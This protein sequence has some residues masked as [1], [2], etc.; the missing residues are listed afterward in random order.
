MPKN[1]Y[2]SKKPFVADLTLCDFSSLDWDGEG[3]LKI[4]QDRGR[5]TA[6]LHFKPGEAIR[7]TMNGRNVRMARITVP[8]T[9]N[10]TVLWVCCAEK[11]ARVRNEEEF[12]RRVKYFRETH[13]VL[14]PEPKMR[15]EWKEN[16]RTNPKNCKGPFLFLV[17]EKDLLIA[18]YSKGKGT[19]CMTVAAYCN[20]DISKEDT[21]RLIEKHKVISAPSWFV[22]STLE[23]AAEGAA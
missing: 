3:T 16:H 21:A 1:F 6:I 7:E 11:E 4:F 18:R 22:S 5:R 2:L 23:K 12:W 9:I 17:E 19:M 14:D 10:K 8:Q 15:P 20:P 13:R